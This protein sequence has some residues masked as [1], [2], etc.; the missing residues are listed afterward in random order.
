MTMAP[1]AI[2]IASHSRSMNGVASLAYGE[3]SMGGG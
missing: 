3:D 1:Y 2:V